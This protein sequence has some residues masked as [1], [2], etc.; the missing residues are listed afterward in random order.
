MKGSLL[1]GSQIDTNIRG[2]L[3]WGN[4]SALVLYIKTIC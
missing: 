2:A 4:E 1:W 3:L